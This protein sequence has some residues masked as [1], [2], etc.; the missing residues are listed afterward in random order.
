MNPTSS[1]SQSVSWQDVPQYPRAAYEIDVLWP[2]LEQNL[3]FF[4]E[5]GA[6]LDPDFQRAHV[7]TDAQRVAWLEYVLR[8]GEVGRT[9]IFA[10][11]DWRIAGRKADG[12]FLVL[13]DGKQRLETVRRFLRNE[14]AVFAG[15][16]LLHGVKAPEEGLRCCDFGGSFRAMLYTLRFRVVETPTRK[17]VLS[18]YLSLN[19]GGTPHTPNELD[20]VQA[21]LDA[22]MEPR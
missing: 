6:D 19:R 5:L 10:C 15:A 9:L 20:R 13:A 7:W 11:S 22:E 18:F 2:T 1:T 3:Q 14:L 4:E 21:L 17:D 16:D 8:G 12:Y